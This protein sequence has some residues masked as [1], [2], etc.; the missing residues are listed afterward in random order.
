MLVFYYMSK[1]LNGTNSTILKN[2]V[3]LALQVSYFNNKNYFS[4][5]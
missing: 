3:D 5:R 1:E 2:A 4:Q